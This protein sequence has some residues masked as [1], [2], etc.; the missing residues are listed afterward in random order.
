MV[1]VQYYCVYKLTKNGEHVEYLDDFSTIQMLNERNKENIVYINDA[2]KALQ[3]K[4]DKKHKGLTYEI[5][6]ISPNYEKVREFLIY[7]QNEDKMKREEDDSPAKI[8]Q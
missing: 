7:L 5:L 3:E 6:K 2:T 8:E 4:L 1:D